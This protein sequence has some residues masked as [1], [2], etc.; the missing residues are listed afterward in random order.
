MHPS[1]SGTILSTVVVL[2]AWLANPVWAK[3]AKHTKPNEVA[4]VKAALPAK[5]KAKPAKPRKLLVFSLCRGFVHGSIPIGAKAIEMMGRKTGAYT[6]V[7]SYDPAVFEPE[8]LKQ[9]DAVCMNNT[10]G[11][12]FLPPD[13][14]KLP[15]AD[16][17]AAS[18]RDAALKKSFLDFVRGGKGLVGVHAA[19]DC[20]Y[21]WS[22]YGE[23]MGGY[24]NGHP[25]GS[26]DTVGVKLDDPAHPLCE[27]FGGLGF[28]IKDEIY[29]FKDKPYSRS[30]L[31]VLLSID[32]ENTNM[33]KKGL[34]RKDGDY[35]ISWIQP[36]GK[37][38]VFYCSL[39]HNNEVFW[40]PAVLQYYLD[41]IQFAIGD[42]P[43]D[44]TP[45]AK[46][47][48]AYIEESQRKVK[49][50]V[51]DK[52]VAKIA[53]HDYGQGTDDF[54]RL[55]DMIIKSHSNA[56]QRA[57]IARKLA[58]LLNGKLTPAARM[59][60]CQQLYRI[61]T[62]DVV[63]Q[64]AR[65]LAKKETADI[66]L[67]ALERMS[68]PAA[69][70]ALRKALGEVTLATKVAVV[71]SLGERRDRQAVEAITKLVGNSNTALAE[72][73]ILALGKIGDAK[74]TAALTKAKSELP[75]CRALAVNDALLMCADG[76]ASS[77]DRS[78]AA[79]IYKMLYARKEAPQTR[80][81]ALVGLVAARPADGVELVIG[82]LQRDDRIVRTAAGG[83]AR[84]L[85]RPGADAA[86]AKAL[87]GLNP[88]AQVLLL[89]AL[90]DRGDSSSKV[91]PTVTAAAGSK[92]SS[93][94]A[95]ALA[96]LGKL[97]D[98]SSVLLLAKAAAEGVDAGV[99]RD[100]LNRLKGAD[101]DSTIIAALSKAEPKVRVELIRSL[102]PRY[103]KGALSS[104][105]KTASDSDESVRSESF[106]ALAVLASAGDLPK[107]LDLLVKE[108]KDGPRGRA[109][110]AA[111][112]LANK[113]K[114]PSKRADAAMAAFPSTKN[115]IPARCALLRV[116]G[117]FQNDRA[118]A[119]LRSCLK[120]SD[121]TLKETAI[122]VL[123]G[124]RT[125]G[126]V[127]DLLEAAGKGPSEATRLVALQAGI[128]L[129]A[130][131]SK[132]SAAETLDL[133]KK[134]L[135]LA[136][137]VQEKKA[138][139][140]GLADAS[141]RRAMDVIKGCMTDKA[142][143]ADAEKALK[144]FKARSLRGSASHGSGEA[145]K[146]YD[147]DIKTRWT[148]GTPMTPGMWYVLDLGWEREI[149][150]I[151]LNSASS[152]GDYPRGYEVYVS[153]NSKEWGKAV[154]KGKG[155]KVLI[156]ITFKPKTGRYVRIVQTGSSDGT[157]WSIH[158]M[159]IG[160]A[161]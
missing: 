103:A 116:F 157:F 150:K 31:R 83:I 138:I 112:A 8:S 147:G 70:A 141:D 100:S 90:G 62:K 30:K 86:L 57:K 130:K 146:A 93:V 154:A 81:A 14:G 117:K 21:E 53:K 23:M 135:A 74:A 69:G 82:A 95:A 11:S 96:T 71:S 59:F 61:G 124:W 29:Q 24:F 133:Y 64:L 161:R 94:R 22:E 152:R 54:N 26:G 84:S 111:I 119:P 41:G 32:H 98:S 145:A 127:K 142:V 49:A 137:R 140:A 97:G 25:W 160:T 3:Q 52:L 6:A 20:L 51:L 1:S 78:G 129:I 43:V 136:K 114:Q 56:K 10:T 77:G 151:V 40:N 48:P 37:G 76:L 35:A 128:R 12:V 28:K 101:I 27:V 50:E 134:A 65:L 108:S 9:F 42:L 126:P 121:A 73:A 106:N 148:S 104:L 17:E 63:P 156:E 5:A 99:A 38:R 120:S 44:T 72:A 47:S 155:T 67:H 131:P 33:K 88:R 19:T 105:W 132:R 36:Y 79:T 110:A 123:A 153:N 115:N 16:K 125:S 34:R 144:K 66:G 13:H 18:K 102:A 139:L 92:D 68:D 149:G 122:R 85:T 4:K 118:L 113:V 58:A 75:P 2:I 15:K 55:S 89:H 45:S 91:L 158:E 80:A 109:E 46:L 7:I 39:G 107:L 60:V 143:K 87:P 159:I